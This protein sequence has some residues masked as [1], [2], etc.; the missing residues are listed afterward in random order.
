MKSVLDFGYGALTVFGGMALL[1]L[2][3][4]FR[5]I[6]NEPVSEQLL[7]IAS[8]IGPALV[9]SAICAASYWLGLRV[10]S[11]HGTGNTYAIGLLCAFVVYAGL[12][13][14]HVLGVDLSPPAHFVAQV[15]VASLVCIVAAAR[16]G[17]PRG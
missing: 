6:G 16:F 14:L 7:V 13:A 15:L 11:R 1:S 9:M 8:L 5:E 12:V 4:F 10:N 17:T 2:A 3:V